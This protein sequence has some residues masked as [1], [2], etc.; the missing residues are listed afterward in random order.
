MSLAVLQG[1]TCV[2]AHVLERAGRNRELGAL[3]SHSKCCQTVREGR[4]EG[5]GRREEG[6]RGG[7][8]RGGGEEGGGEEGRREGGRREEGRGGGHYITDVE[9][10]L[11]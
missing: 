4:G 11:K 10:K 8:R 1:H 5:G 3:N 9:A 2:L 7:G 6:R